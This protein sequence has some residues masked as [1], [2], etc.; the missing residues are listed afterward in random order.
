MATSFG[1]DDDDY[2]KRIVGDPKDTILQ[3]GLSTALG[4]I[5]FMTFCARVPPIYTVYKKLT[6]VNSLCG[7]DG[8]ECTLRESGRDKLLGPYPI[9]PKHSSDG[10]QHYGG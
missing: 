8:R 10:C 7:H 2:R 6:R 9:S 3:I 5:A 4:L 1:T